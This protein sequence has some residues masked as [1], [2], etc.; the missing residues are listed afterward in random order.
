MGVWKVK[1][2]EKAM[3]RSKAL[4]WATYL[5]NDESHLH[6]YGQIWT[7]AE[8]PVHTDHV[9]ARWRGCRGSAEKQK[10]F[11]V[12]LERPGFLCCG[13]IISADDQP[14]T[15]DTEHL[16]VPTFRSP[17]CHMPVLIRRHIYPRRSLTCLSMPESRYLASRGQ[18]LCTLRP[19]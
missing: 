16:H 6:E 12:S 9:S 19:R 17:A 14:Y 2:S 3:G 1:K 10:G 5:E 11:A 18:S 7:T 13:D 8:S 4:N 15:R